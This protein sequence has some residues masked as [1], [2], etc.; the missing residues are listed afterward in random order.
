MSIAGE[1]R[2][3]S[4]ISTAKSGKSCKLPLPVRR[5]TT[6]PSALDGSAIVS[7]LCFLQGTISE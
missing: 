7:F 2:T 5:R 3:S 6:R 1:I 4:W